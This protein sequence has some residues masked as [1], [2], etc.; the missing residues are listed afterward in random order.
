M[1]AS[2]IFS[3]R[4]SKSLAVEPKRVRASYWFW[5]VQ[6]LIPLLTTYLPWSPA[7]YHP[8]LTSRL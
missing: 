6:T 2:G 7:S 5:S 1:P 4:S 3:F 8:P